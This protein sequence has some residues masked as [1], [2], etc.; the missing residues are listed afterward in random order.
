MK[1]YF[2]IMLAILCFTALCFA[3]LEQ[4]K[5]L[6]ANSLYLAAVGGYYIYELRIEEKEQ[7]YKRLK[8]AI[9]NFILSESEAARKEIATAQDNNRKGIHVDLEKLYEVGGSGKTLT[10]L[11]ELINKF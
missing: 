8:E 1:T 11:N 7:Q 4:W 2:K 10:S 3:V 5:Q 6:M 9:K